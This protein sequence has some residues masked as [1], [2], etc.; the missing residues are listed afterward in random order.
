MTGRIPWWKWSSAATAV[1][2]TA[3]A[4]WFASRPPKPPQIVS[5]DV[6]VTGIVQQGKVLPVPSPNPDK[7]TPV[8]PADPERAEMLT[9]LTVYVLSGSPGYMLS[10]SFVLRGRSGNASTEGVLAGSGLHYRCAYRR[11]QV[12][13]EVPRAVH[14]DGLSFTLS[15]SVFAPNGKAETEPVARI[16]T[17]A[18][19]REGEKTVVGKSS[20][21]GTGDALILM[22]VPKLID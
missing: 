1:I 4:A 14:I 7:L 20:I 16:N 9:K 21:G 5:V 6:N 2:I 8:A 19:L 22:I 11:L 10:D 12:S 13:G 3:S 18:D 15:K 17:D